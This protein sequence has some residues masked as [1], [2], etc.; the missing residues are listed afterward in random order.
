MNADNKVS[1]EPQQHE[2]GSP[3][4]ELAATPNVSPAINGKG[5]DQQERQTKKRVE[6]ELVMTNRMYEP[7][8]N[9]DQESEAKEPPKNAEQSKESDINSEEVEDADDQNPIAAYGEPVEQNATSI[10]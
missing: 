7:N 2:V 9:T 1:I 5:N 10:V 3:P 4:A 6:N 8:L